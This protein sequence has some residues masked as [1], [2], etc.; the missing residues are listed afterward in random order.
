MCVPSL[1][2]SGTD[3]F[4]EK[5]NLILRGDVLASFPRLFY[6]KVKK[7]VSVGFAQTGYPIKKK[8]TSTVH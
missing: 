7:Q 8:E 4:W 6:E 3:S 1:A 5:N 2:H